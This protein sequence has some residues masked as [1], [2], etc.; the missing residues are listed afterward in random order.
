MIPGAMTFTYEQARRYALS[1]LR[2][3]IELQQAEA[4]RALSEQKWWQFYLD[5]HYDLDR[6]QFIEAEKESFC[7]KVGLMMEAALGFITQVK[8]GHYATGYAFQIKIWS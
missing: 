1:Q 5:E 2:E 3:D 6:C 7:E 8:F 4:K